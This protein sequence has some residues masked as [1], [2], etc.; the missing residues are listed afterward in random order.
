MEIDMI[1][2]IQTKG[3]FQLG[4]RMPFPCDQTDLKEVTRFCPQRFRVETT[5]FSNAPAT[6]RG[7]RIR[8]RAWPPSLL[9]TRTS[10]PTSGRYDTR[11]AGDGLA[12][13]RSTAV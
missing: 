3:H 9:P 10:A 5:D 1:I 13:V 11:P 6:E 2:W 8:R 7:T 4:K 12:F